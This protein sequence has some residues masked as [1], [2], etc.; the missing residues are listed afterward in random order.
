MKEGTRNMEQHQAVKPNINIERK[1]LTGVVRLV[2]FFM[3][4]PLIASLQQWLRQ[5]LSNK[6]N[7][8]Q[9]INKIIY[10]FEN[11]TSED[12]YMETTKQLK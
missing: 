10:D 9:E 5:D 3:V 11:N 6:R 7:T 12:R 4:F 1:I 8:N 2:I